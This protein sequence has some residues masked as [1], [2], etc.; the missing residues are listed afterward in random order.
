MF[1]KKI[2]ITDVSNVTMSY[3]ESIAFDAIERLTLYFRLHN[4]CR[5]KYPVLKNLGFLSS[6]KLTDV[7]TV[8]E[9]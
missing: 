1:S 2:V 6:L 8:V 5:K 4:W 7:K 9:E 3:I